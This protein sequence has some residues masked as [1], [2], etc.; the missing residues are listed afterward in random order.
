MRE[1]YFKEGGEDSKN[2]EIRGAGLWKRSGKGVLKPKF[3]HQQTPKKFNQGYKT[4]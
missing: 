2:N 1:L 4:N 3:D